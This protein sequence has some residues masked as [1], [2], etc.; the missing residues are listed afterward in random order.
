[1]GA[2]SQ[3]EEA[4]VLS[5]KDWAR[6]CY[7]RNHN[8]IWKQDKMLM[9]Q[10]EAL[11][12]LKKESVSLYESAIQFDPNIIPITFKGPVATPPIKDYIQD[13]EYKETTQTFKVIYED[14]DQF[15]KDLLQRSRKKKRNPL[16]KKNK[17]S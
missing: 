15:M 7:T 5:M 11:D 16:M 17:Q 9:T 1:M 13:G 8:E 2:S 10:Q 6:H 4:R 12:E 14:T 3:E